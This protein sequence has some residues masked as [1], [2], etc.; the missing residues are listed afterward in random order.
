MSNMSYCRFRN[1]LED[2][3]NCE[4]NL[5]DDLSESIEEAQARIKLVEV[6]QRI[7]NKADIDWF[8]EELEEAKKADS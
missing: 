6:C 4:R 3:M 2:L 5:D 7:V 1:T 8:R